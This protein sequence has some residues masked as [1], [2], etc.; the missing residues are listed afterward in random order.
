MFVDGVDC[1]REGGEYTM[2]DGSAAVAVCGAPT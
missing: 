1:G 2:R